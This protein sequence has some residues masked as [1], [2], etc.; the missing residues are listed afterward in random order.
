MAT[1]GM[2]SG[3]ACCFGCAQVLER[4]STYLPDE[5]RSSQALQV[6]VDKDTGNPKAHP[7]RGGGRI[8]VGS[9]MNVHAGPLDWRGQTNAL[10]P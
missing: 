10:S 3:Y 1:Q 5:H 8:R 9:G 6:G 7:G 4:L 2:R